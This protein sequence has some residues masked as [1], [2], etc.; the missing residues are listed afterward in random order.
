[1]QKRTNEGSGEVARKR[2]NTTRAEIISTAT[3]LFLEKGYTATS[4]NAICEELN[5]STGN[6]TY[7]FQTK[8][9]LLAVLVEMLCQFQWKCMQNTV[10]EGMTSVLAVCLELAFMVSV[11][12]DDESA[13]DFYLAA[14]SH[15]MTIEIIRKNDTQ[16]AKTVYQQ[17][18]PG[19]TEEQFAEAELLVSGIEF[20][21]LMPTELPVSME[22]RIA[23]AINSILTIY[24]VPENIRQE[25]VKKVL[26]Q[27][28]RSLGKKVLQRFKD[29]VEEITGI[30]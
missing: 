11:C 3:R 14:Y 12:E 6:L 5:L 16:R 10:Q 8:E 26:A 21:T 7:Y 30:I 29:Y 18:C 28:Y 1:M 24:N 17:Y 2:A 4:P 27:D 15:P 22:S 19:W 9:H 20:A 13:K 23:G 25:K